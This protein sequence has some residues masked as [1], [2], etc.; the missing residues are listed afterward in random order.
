MRGMLEDEATMKKAAMMKAMQ[1][2]NKRL[3][4]AKR[5]R[6]NQ[7]KNQQ[8]NKNKFELD[9]TINQRVQTELYGETVNQL[10]QT[11]NTLLN[12]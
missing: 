4:Q 2:E 3:A 12:K 11:L 8:A 10:G 7:W 1:D 6:E 5:D 9:A